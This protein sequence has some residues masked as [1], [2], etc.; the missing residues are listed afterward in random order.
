MRSGYGIIVGFKGCRVWSLGLA[1]N[2]GLRL[3]GHGL[4]FGIRV[5]L[6]HNKTL[7]KNI[8]RRAGESVWVSKLASSPQIRA[9]PR[10]EDSSSR[11]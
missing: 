4:V 10:V 5:Y 1:S 2:Y 9:A 6:P 11:R 7:Y 8:C 3:E